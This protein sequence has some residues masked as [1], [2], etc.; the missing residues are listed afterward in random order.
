M[1]GVLSVLESA[2]FSASIMLGTVV[3]TESLSAAILCLR[4]QKGQFRCLMTQKVAL[5]VAGNMLHYG[6]LQRCKNRCEKIELSSI[7]RNDSGNKKIRE[8]FVAGYVTL[9]NFSR[10]LLVTKLRDKLYEALPSVKAPLRI[11][12]ITNHLSFTLNSE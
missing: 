11:S 8:M 3:A 10:N 5:H 4:R 1:T 2:L 9:D 6:S 7:S 12:I